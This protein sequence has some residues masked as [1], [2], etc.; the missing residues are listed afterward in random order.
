[1]QNIWDKYSINGRKVLRTIWKNDGISRIEIAGRLNLDKSTITKIT[2]KLLDDGI[3]VTT[4]IGD[5]GPLGGR[6]PVSLSLAGH[7]GFILGIELRT[8]ECYG[9]LVNLKGEIIGEF[10]EPYSGNDFSSLV[11]SARKLVSTVQEEREISAVGIGLSGIVNYRE[12]IVLRSYPLSLSEPYDIRNQLKQYF[13]FP[14]FVEN[15]ANCG[16]WSE[17]I[18]DRENRKA[19][20]IY[21]TGKLDR[22]VKINDPYRG[23]G[24]GAGILING[25][26]LHGTGY[27]AGEFRSV[28]SED[29]ETGQLAC[30]EENERLD[31]L[32]RN[33]AMIINTFNINEIVLG[34]DFH[35]FGKKLLK[36]F[37]RRAD[38]NWAYE[39]PA[40]CRFRYSRFGEMDVAYGA[41]SMCL[42]NFF[43]VK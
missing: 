15:D 36:L 33:M 35:R 10:E 31:E 42:D 19:N 43:A 26:V 18:A 14:V 7:K 38:G 21:L 39:G 4:D 40:D 2:N 11:L 27:S 37:A 5:P 6:R 1:M 23:S 3:V 41:A 30:D 24:I 13:D 22:Q 32:A 16:C 17:L 20:M 12:G 9:L 34:G 29:K 8:D 25:K 28:F